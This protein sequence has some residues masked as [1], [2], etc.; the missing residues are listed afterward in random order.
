MKITKVIKLGLICSQSDKDGVEVDYKEINK[1]LWELQ[2]QTRE[3]KNKSIQ[4]CWEY[5][6]FESEYRQKN[7]EY[8]KE[9]EILGF[10]LDG[11]I[12]NRLKGNYGLFSGNLS[13]SSRDACRAFKN[14]KWDILKGKKS[15]IDY[16]ENQPL[17]IHNKCIVLENISNGDYF[18][19][20]GLISKELKKQYNF[21]DTKIRFK[22]IVRDKSTKIILDRC[23][24][25]QYSICASK[26]IYNK[27]KKMWFLNLSYKFDIEKSSTL[28]KTKILGVDLGVNYPICASIYNDLDRFIVY[29]GEIEQFRIKIEARKQ[30]LLKQ[31]KSCGDGRVGHGIKTRNRPV[32]KIEDKI[33]RFRDTANHKYSRALIQYAVKH[34]CGVIQMENLQGITENANRFMKNWTYYDLQMKI[35]NKAKELG[36]DVRYINPKY[37]SQMCSKCGYIDSSNRPE[38]KSFICGKC[39]FKENADYNASQ[40]ISII[41]IDKIIEDDIK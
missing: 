13:T 7:S 33:A 3:I 40:N 35:E 26:L 12:N 21:K 11:F 38:Q 27:K 10:T 2:H 31:G 18:V 30:S 25:K 41:D 5:Y 14:A 19:Y 6:G 22:V 17:D 28:D 16:K 39:G 29:G 8:P 15:I 4:Y 24:N 23:L 1:L 34:N 9:K 20:L 36:I 32:Y 37:T